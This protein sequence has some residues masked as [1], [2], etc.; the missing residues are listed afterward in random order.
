MSPISMWWCP[1]S[2]A[3]NSAGTTIRRRMSLIWRHS[4]LVGFARAQG[5][6]DGNKRSG[7]ACALV[8]L[9]ENGAALH[10]DGSEL[11]ALTMRVAISQADDGKVAAY[12]RERL[13]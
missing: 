1:P 13:S 8:F 10:V 7:L 12:L 11:Y 9:A 4:I 5:F 6:V 2:R 3:R